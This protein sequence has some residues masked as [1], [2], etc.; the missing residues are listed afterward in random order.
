MEF[1]KI[2]SSVSGDIG[3]TK[4]TSE[5]HRQCWSRVN[6]SKCRF[7]SIPKPMEYT[8]LVLGKLD[9][10]PAIAKN[11]RFACALS[12]SRSMLIQRRA[13]R[14]IASD[15][16]FTILDT[17]APCVPMMSPIMRKKQPLATH[18][19]NM[20]SC[21]TGGT[22]GPRGSSRSSSFTTSRTVSFRNRK[23]SRKPSSL[24]AS[25][26]FILSRITCGTGG[27]IASWRRRNLHTAAIFKCHSGSLQPSLNFILNLKLSMS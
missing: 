13:I 7:F 8:G 23:R 9:H 4:C 12:L 5:P 25:N 18:N 2:C 27:L 10:L 3:V 11:A 19:K 24:N 14:I 21:T 6:Y 16:L 26:G 15:T 22:N 1:M 17:E 20:Q